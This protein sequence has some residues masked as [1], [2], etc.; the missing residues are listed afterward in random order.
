M[1]VNIHVVHPSGGKMHFYV[2]TTIFLLMIY[3]RAHSL[4]IPQWQ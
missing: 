2:W 1:F 4:N 3:E